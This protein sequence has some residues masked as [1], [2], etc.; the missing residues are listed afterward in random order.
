MIYMMSVVFIYN[1]VI[2]TVILYMISKIV[3]PL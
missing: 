3:E 2:F 1:A